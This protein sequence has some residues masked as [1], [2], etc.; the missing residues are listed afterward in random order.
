MD[1]NLPEWIAGYVGIPY[2]KHGRTREGADCWGLIQM[3]QAEQ[4]GSAWPQYEGV[5]WYDGQ[6]PE[7]IG[8]SAIRYASYFR[9]LGRNEEEQLGDGI[10]LRMRGH[11]FHVGMVLT[12]GWMIHSNEVSGSAIETYRDGLW[13]KRVTGIYRYEKE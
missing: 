13:N 4:M 8:A 6:K 9:Q 5:D 12:P 11:P 10:L 1:R 2:A 7:T 3:I